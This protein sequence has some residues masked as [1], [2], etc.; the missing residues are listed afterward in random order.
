MK[1][2]FLL[3]ALFISSVLS[4]YAQE[5]ATIL[6]SYDET[7]R[8]WET[9][10]I[11]NERMSLLANTTQSKYFNDISLW[12]DS[13]SSTPEGKRQLR[14]IIMATCITE[15]PGGGISIDKRKG[16]AKRINKY[17]FNNLTDKTLTFYGKF[18][19]DY[20][21]YTEPTDEI[22]W[23][24]GDSTITILGYECVS[25][26]TNYH[27]RRWTAWFAPELPMPFGPWK[28]RGLPGLIL[29]AVDDNGDSFTAD[30]IQQT[31]R[32]ISPIY[33]PENYTK[34]DRKKALAEQKYFLENREAIIKAKFGSSVR[35]ENNGKKQ[36][37]YDTRKYSLEP[38]FEE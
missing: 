22:R 9:D 35:F 24:I 19:E 34:K 15:L 38:D 17:V 23:E 36:P 27:G 6:L 12:N 18:G 32:I 14:Q 5:K 26:T 30:G 37:K 13:L 33:S 25:A 31:D 20:N 29:K 10:T 7:G 3:I 16:P 28:L 2:Q 11:I 1:K 21:Y 4:V 8:N